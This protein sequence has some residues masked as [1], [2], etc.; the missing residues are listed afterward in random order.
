[1]TEGIF[2]SCIAYSSSVSLRLPPSP[3]GEG[4]GNDEMNSVGRIDIRYVLLALAYTV[5]HKPYGT[6][7]RRTLPNAFRARNDYFV[8][9]KCTPIGRT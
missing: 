4:T 3:A 9:L 8:I 6:S 1:M 5:S 2:H 7:G